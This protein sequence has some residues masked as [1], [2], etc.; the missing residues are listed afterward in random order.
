[1]KNLFAK[2]FIA[3]AVIIVL[4]F[5]VLGCSFL[6]QVNRFAV[7]EKH[8]VLE[9][10]LK[11]AVDSTVSYIEL[12]MDMQDITNQDTVNRLFKLYTTNMSQIA[13]DSDSTMFVCQEDGVLLLVANSDGC[14]SQQTG[15]IPT[16][17]INGFNGSDS[18][19]GVSTM[20]GYLGSSA[21]VM[22]SKTTIKDGSSL[23][24]F[25]TLPA[26]TTLSLFSRLSQYFVMMTVLVL[27]LTL[28]VTIIVVRQTVKPM[29]QIA[30]AS[31]SFAKG[32]YSARVPM[33]KF[34]HGS[35]LYELAAA[36]NNMA[37]A[38]ENV[39]MT[40]RGLVA[41]VA[42]D[43]RTPMTTIAGFVDGI[44]DGTIKPDRQEYYL[45]IVSDEVKR[46]SRMASSILEMSRL[47][48]GEKAL[49][50][51]LY[52]ITE[53]VRRIII[54]FEQKI[55]QKNIELEIDIPD[56]I[57]IT[58]DHDAM[59][60][61]VYN[62][63]DN[64]LKFVEQ[65]GK[66]IIYMSEHNG[67]LQFNIINTGGE[68]AKEDIKFIFDR[69]YKGDQSRTGSGSG[70]GLGLYIVKTVV[71]RHGGDVFAKSENNRTEFC[72]RIPIKAEATQENR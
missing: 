19:Y 7:A 3:N 25:A 9:T 64:A 65:N 24:V 60:Q 8:S 63:M 16:G 57:N 41:N 38:F 15:V 31:K 69:F 55:A 43:L 4:S 44:L 30:L 70:S 11:Q 71:N 58:A 56:R 14:Y 32:N 39:E 17:I 1:M 5:V 12:R 2:H 23:L 49:N 37:D 68:I 22:G 50:P 13:A 42:H 45:R 27:I 35:E 10:T 28:I 29:R 6:Y 62:L 67:E 34:K 40:R 51:V 54:S 33:P 52:D 21:F 20:G 53:T 61:A 47:E 48:S 46:L 36:F 72:F 66:I 26:T 18:Y 59:F